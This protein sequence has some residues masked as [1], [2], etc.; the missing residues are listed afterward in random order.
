MGP[1]IN[2]RRR[3]RRPHRLLG[4]PYE[5]IDAIVVGQRVFSDV[6][7]FENGLR[8]AVNKQLSEFYGTKW[9]ETSLGLRKEQELIDIYNYVN[10]QRLQR[11]KMPWLGDSQR[12]ELLPLHAITLGQLQ[13][14]VVQY[15][16][17]LIPQLFP[18]LDFFTGHLEVIKRVR[19]LFAHMYPCITNKD[20]QVAKREIMTICDHLRTKL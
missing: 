7:Q 19:N 2:K 8:L 14:I 3:F 18:S 4:I 5:Y 16:S 1:V 11:N 15:K 17:D 12:V 10:Q 13:Q 6:F 9:W 20:A